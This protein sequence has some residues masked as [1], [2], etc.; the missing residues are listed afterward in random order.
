[1]NN[2]AERFLII[3][4]LFYLVVLLAIFLE[5]LTSVYQVK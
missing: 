1:M 3:A 5:K 4:A 2:P